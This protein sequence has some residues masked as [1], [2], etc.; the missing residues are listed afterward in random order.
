[1]AKAETRPPAGP[2]ASLACVFTSGARTAG[3]AK[4]R[5]AS[6]RVRKPK[7]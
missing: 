2:I 3:V 1:M 4:S 7:S 6:L 5:F